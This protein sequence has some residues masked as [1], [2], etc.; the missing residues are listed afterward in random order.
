MRPTP[1]QIFKTGQLHNETMDKEHL[2]QFKF[3]YNIKQIKLITMKIVVIGGSGLIGSKTVNKLKEKGHEVIAASPATGVNTITGEGLSEALE[4]ADKVV[5]VANSPSFEDNAVMEFFKTSGHN[6]LM[7]EKRAGTKHHIALSIVGVDRLPESG[8][9]RAKVEQERLIR[10]SG[11]PYSI[12]HS[13]QFFE[14]A[15]AIV[16]EGTVGDAIHLSTGL[17]QPIASDDVVDALVDVVLDDPI[18]GIIEVGG[19]EKVGMDRFARKYLDAKQDTHEV[20]GDPQALYFGTVIDDHSLVPDESAR[21][22]SIRY[23][24]WIRIPGNLR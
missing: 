11:V 8:Y 3:N 7:A 5:D 21:I 10:E 12:L 23:D 6:L 15:G 2:Y 24:D 22:G 1:V 16:K 19:P 14:F 9:L 18:N 17:F 4:G 20:I 13:T